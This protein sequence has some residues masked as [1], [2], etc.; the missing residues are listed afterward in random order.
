MA[1]KKKNEKYRSRTHLL[2]LYP[3]NESHCEALEKIKKSYDC[4]Y[5]LHD[6]DVK[7]DGTPKKPHWHVVL[8]FPNAKWNSS[9][10]D[11][12]GI[13]ER[14]TEEPRSFDNSLLYLIHFND[15]DKFQYDVDDVKGSIKKRVKELINKSNK[16]EGEKVFELIEFIDNYEDR[17]SVKDF[18]RFCASNGYW[19]EFRRSGMI[20]CKIIEE[21]NSNVAQIQHQKAMEKNAQKMAELTSHYRKEKAV[22]ENK[23]QQIDIDFD[24]IFN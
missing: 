1:Q 11:E 7:D 8:R 13:E 4:A 12:L 10:A 15:S 24:K 18:A 20:F 23:W 19:A 22:R 17:L 21:H 2:E 3:D 5:I 14:F 16:S 6:K 9:L